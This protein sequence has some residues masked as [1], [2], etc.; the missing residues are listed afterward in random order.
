MGTTTPASFKSLMVVLI[1][2][3]TS[4]DVVLLLI[5]C[6]GQG[7][8]GGCAIS[9]ASIWFQIMEPMCIHPNYSL[10]RRGNNLKSGSMDPL[11][12]L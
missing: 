11:G 8:V 2:S 10:G 9:G 12:P 6:F 7:H 4:W 3:V 5:Y 1:S